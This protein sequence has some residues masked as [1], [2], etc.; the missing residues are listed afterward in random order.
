[1]KPA[2]RKDGSARESIAACEAAPTSATF[3]STPMSDHIAPIPWFDVLLLLALVTL[4]GVLAMGELAIV[5]SREAR[6][7]AMARSAAAARNARSTSPPTPAASCRR[8]RAGSP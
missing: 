1:M 8:C 6:L 4:N 2:H 3:A 5:S 7:K